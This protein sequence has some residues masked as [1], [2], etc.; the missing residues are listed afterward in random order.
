MVHAYGPVRQPQRQFVQMCARILATE[1]AGFQKALAPHGQKI[2][3]I[4]AGDQQFGRP[5]RL[6]D[7]PSPMPI[8]V[9]LVLIGVDQI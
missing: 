6:E 2:A 7:R 8:W 1:P 9:K 4:H 5:I 3:E